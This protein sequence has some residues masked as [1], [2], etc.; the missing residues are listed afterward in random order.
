[1]SIVMCVNRILLLVITHFEIVIKHEI[2]EAVEQPHSVG[3]IAFQATMCF[4]KAGIVK[5]WRQFAIELWHWPVGR[6]VT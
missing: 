3:E 5:V 4:S 1:M 2:K 6:I